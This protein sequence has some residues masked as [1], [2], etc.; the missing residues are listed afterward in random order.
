M[1]AL[2]GIVATV[3]G[4][5]RAIKPEELANPNCDTETWWL[6]AAEYPLEAMQSVLF[7][8][9][10]LEAPE[11]WHAMEEKCLERWVKKSVERLSPAQ[12]HVYAAACAAHVLHLWRKEEPTDRAPQRAIR[13]RR[14]LAKNGE[15]AKEHWLRCSQEA[16]AASSKLFR[17]TS[18]LGAGLG[19]DEAG[20]AAKAAATEDLVLA[21]VCAAHAMAKKAVRKHPTL[22]N[23]R[24]S[25]P[26]YDSTYRESL[27]K[28]LLWQWARLQQYLRGEVP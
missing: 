3:N 21:V 16:E 12:G 17:R 7:P 23:M 6:I 2:Q 22:G 25:D 18:S 26:L 5:I 20:E 15:S 14:L 11:R 28:E 9:L 24:Y 4:I 27:R 10:T 13:A 19:V 1:S 8:L